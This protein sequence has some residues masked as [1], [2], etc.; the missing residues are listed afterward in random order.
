MLGY[1]IAMTIQGLVLGAL[2][3]LV[4]AGRQPM[5]CVATILCGLGGAL[6]GGVLGRLLFGEDYAPGL[7]MGTIC[8][9]LLIWLLYGTARNPR[10]G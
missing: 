7:I 8:S 5:G 9:A 2:G 4:V 6:I 1:V 10:V 3:R